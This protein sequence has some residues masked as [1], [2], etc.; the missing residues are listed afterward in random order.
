M[1]DEPE[2]GVGHDRVVLLV[3]VARGRDVVQLA[4]AVCEG[5]GQAVRRILGKVALGVGA[6]ARDPGCISRLGQREKPCDD[7]A[8]AATEAPVIARI[9]RPAVA[10]QDRRTA[11][12]GPA[13]VAAKA[14]VRRKCPPHSWGGGL[15]LPIYGEV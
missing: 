14:T 9:L 4:A 3:L 10:D 12:Q 7:T 5:D 8:R 13:Y 6:S 15:V 11:G 2:H 1:L